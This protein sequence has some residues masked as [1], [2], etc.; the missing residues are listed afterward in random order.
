ME[1][2]KEIQIFWVTLKTCLAIGLTTLFYFILYSDLTRSL[3]VSPIE[4]RNECNANDEGI[5][6][7]RKFDVPTY[8]E[9]IKKQLGEIPRNQYLVEKLAGSTPELFKYSIG[10]NDNSSVTAWKG[11]NTT[12]FR[13]DRGDCP[14]PSNFT[15]KENGGIFTE[16]FGLF[17]V[18]DKLQSL[19]T[20]LNDC[21]Q[22]TKI[23][24]P[25]MDRI[26]QTERYDIFI[27]LSHGSYISLLFLALLLTSLV[28]A[29]FKTLFRFIAKDLAE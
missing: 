17:S 5:L 21:V 6:C 27:K 28:V 11:Q 23:L 2:K 3:G 15:A 16:R 20:A 25:G 7:S 13:R 10:F 14:F 29:A 24:P 9:D 12:P 8:F 26:E 4:I 19:A 1:T 18:A 22:K